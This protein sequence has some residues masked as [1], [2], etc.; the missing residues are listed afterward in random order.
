MPLSLVDRVTSLKPSATV[1]MTE[2]VRAARA[3]GRRILALSSG[4]PSIDT[5]PRIIDAAERAMRGGATHYGPAAGLPALREAIALREQARSGTAYDPNDIIVTPGGKFALLTALM[6]LVEAGDEVLV[7]EPGWVSYGPCVRLCGGT[8]VPLALLDRLDLEML[9]RA[10]TPRTK[11]VIINSPVNPTGRVLSTEEISGLVEFAVRHDIWIVFDQVYC[12]LLHSGRFP[13]PQ[14]LPGGRERTFVVDSFSKTFGMTG[15]RLGALMMPAGLSKA[16]LKFMQHSVYCVP[17]FIQLAGIQA[18]SLYDE[19]VPQYRET[20]RRRLETAVAGLSKID[21]ITTSM[22]SATFYLFP[23]I[24][25]D[26]VAVAKRWL[27]EIDVSSLPGSFFG[28][29]GKGHLRLSLTCPDAD[30]EEALE[31]IA[32]AGLAA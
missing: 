29:P 32:R 16:V 28:A 2:R 1:E 25:G 27:D 19:V 4:D 13:S 20:F 9:E 8:P 17:D 10:V 22:P 18:L 12:D 7:P 23:A 31:R 5:D 11:A 14:A 6:A 26:D 3:S 30:L 21:G 24:A 15:W